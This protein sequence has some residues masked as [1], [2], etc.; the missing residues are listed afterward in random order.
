VSGRVTLLDECVRAVGALGEPTTREV[1]DYLARKWPEPEVKFWSV[2]PTLGRLARAERPLIEVAGRAGHGRAVR[3]RVT[4]A[5]REWLAAGPGGEP[6]EAR[7]R[8]GR[9]QLPEL[10]VYA[11]G[12]LGGTASTAEVRQFFADAGGPE[13]RRTLAATL[14][15]LA[16]RW[17]PPAVEQVGRATWRLTERGHQMIADED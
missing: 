16:F 1:A 9:R 17:Q 14:A 15:N 13:A 2:R 7:P 12:A 10:C 5:G 8:W 6:G 3:W 4:G 11:I